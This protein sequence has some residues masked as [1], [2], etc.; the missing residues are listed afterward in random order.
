MAGC[1]RYARESGDEVL[2]CTLTLPSRFHCV[3][4]KTGDQNSKFDGSDVQ[5]GQRQLQSSWA[6]VRAALHRARVAIY[7]F[8]CTEPNHDGTVHWHMMICARP[9]TVAV[10]RQT[11]TRYFLDEI[12]PAEPGAGDHPMARVSLRGPGYSRPP[13]SARSG[14]SGRSGRSFAAAGWFPKRGNRI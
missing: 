4:S 11:I 5:A 6:K 8:R 13:S 3:H 12:E 7:G 1:E 2:V 10:V 9:D 14:L